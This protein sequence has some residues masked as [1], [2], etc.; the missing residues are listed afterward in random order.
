[1]KTRLLN[2]FLGLYGLLMFS[3]Y[4]LDLSA[5]ASKTLPFHYL[6]DGQKHQ[7]SVQI[8]TKKIVYS[9][10]GSEHPFTLGNYTAQLTCPSDSEC[11]FNLS[12]KNVRW[13]SSNHNTNE[14]RIYL[15]DYEQIPGLKL[16]SPGEF[17]AIG[18]NKQQSKVLE[19]ELSRNAS[20]SFPIKFKIYNNGVLSNAQSNSESETVFSQSYR[21]GINEPHKDISPNKVVQN[22]SSSSPSTTSNSTKNKSE[23]TNKSASNAKKSDKDLWAE[24]KQ[25]DNL[26]AYKTYIQNYPIGKYSKNA[27]N[28]IDSLFWAVAIN[29]YTIETNKDTKEKILENYLNQS[30]NGAY[31]TEAQNKIAAL[32]SVGSVNSVSESKATS[33]TLPNNDASTEQATDR[34]SAKMDFNEGKKELALSNIQGGTPPYYIQFKNQSGYTSQQFLIGEQST[35]SVKLAS[36]SQ[37]PQGELNVFLTDANKSSLYELGYVNNVYQSFFAQQYL[38]IALFLIGLLSI[39]SII[40]FKQKKDK[41]RVREW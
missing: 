32:Q 14:L 5:Q 40:Y 12:F 23:Q 20:S 19:F 29:K 6:Q 31:R 3:V 21:V 37:L 36:L 8:N 13:A 26:D 30:P 24:V 25:K 17:F 16:F 2:Y 15:E 22:K 28:K 10:K 39:I 1:M 41:Q 33:N 27:I 4:S 35:K 34:A 11:F 7:G 18:Q 9:D 38:L